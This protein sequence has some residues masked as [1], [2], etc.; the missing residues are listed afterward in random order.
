MPTIKEF[1]EGGI[2]AAVFVLIVLPYLYL[3]LASQVQ[4]ECTEALKAAM[5]R[6][7]T[8]KRLKKRNFNE[9]IED[10]LHVFQV[11]WWFVAAFGLIMLCMFKLDL[12][13]ELSTYFKKVCV[14]DHSLACQIGGSNAPNSA[15][16]CPEVAVSCRSMRLVLS[17]YT[18]GIGI[19]FAFRLYWERVMATRKLR[20]YYIDD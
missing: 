11:D 7:P 17:L 6:N 16:N 19:A 14:S 20:A 4:L 8:W 3:N 15:S 12:L 10:A 1:L 13:I 2:I 5:G 18:L 9:A